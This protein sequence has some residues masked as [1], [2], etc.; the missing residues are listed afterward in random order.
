MSGVDVRQPSV[1]REQLRR[2]GAAGEE[3]HRLRLPVGGYGGAG[4]SPLFLALSMLEIC[5]EKAYF[6]LCR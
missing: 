5:S 3:D 2:H 4:F 1:R 6:R